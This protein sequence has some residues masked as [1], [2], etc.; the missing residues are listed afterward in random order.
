LV[1]W[2]TGLV[3]FTHAHTFVRLH[4]VGYVCWYDHGWRCLHVCYTHF[5]FLV[6]FGLRFV[7]LPV[8][9][10]LFRG[11]VYG[12][13]FCWL[14][15]THL[16][17]YTLGW[18]VSS[19][20]PLFTRLVV[21]YAIYVWFHRLVTVTTVRF[22]WLV[23]RYVG[24]FL[25]LRFTFRLPVWLRFYVTR[26]VY[27]HARLPRLLHAFAFTHAR[28]RSRVPFGF[29][30]TTG[31][32]GSF[33]FVGWTGTTLHTPLHTRLRLHTVPFVLGWFRSVTHVYPTRSVPVCVYGSHTTVPAFGY[34]HWLVTRYG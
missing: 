3:G 28:L 17:P 22:I 21:G 8:G 15:F 31:L 24:T 6:T 18:F 32:V 9:L 2:V 26:L 7:G 19:R 33:R 20:F 12:W 34:L 25:V 27:V 4:T 13:L 11:Y 5:F 14:L 29:A 1:V 10:R 16:Y 30:V 23:A